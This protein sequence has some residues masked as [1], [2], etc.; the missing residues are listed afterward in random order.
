MNYKKRGRDVFDVVVCVILSLLALIALF[1]IA[2]G[3][4][5]VK[6]YVVGSSMDGTLTGASRKDRAGGDYVYIFRTSS[7]S[8]GDIVV[9]KTDD[10]PIIKRVIALG[11]DTVALKSG[12]L[13]VNGSV[14]D[15]PYVKEEN[16]SASNPKNTFSEITVPKGEMFF[17]GDN[18]DVSVDS[19]SDKYGTLPVGNTMGVVADWSLSFKSLFTSVNT[20]FDFKLGGGS[21]GFYG[22]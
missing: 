3:F 1:R 20:F 16:N 9:I 11:G 12:V 5:Y 2:F 10:E 18:R 13:Y 4:T 6:V 21:S 8:R 22:G 15:E 19:R 17:L 7:P 14:V